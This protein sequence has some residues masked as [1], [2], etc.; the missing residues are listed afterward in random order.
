MLPLSG[1]GPLPCL[2][3]AVLLTAVVVVLAERRRVR[4]LGVPE[5]AAASG[6]TAPS[7]PMGPLTAAGLTLFVVL[8]VVYVIFVAANGN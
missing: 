8:V 7:R 4:R 6:E 3:G 2:V 5:D 1:M